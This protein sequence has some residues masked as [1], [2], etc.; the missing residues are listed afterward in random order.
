MLKRM[1]EPGLI[2]FSIGDL[3]FSHSMAHLLVR[4]MDWR[5]T[6]LAG[7]I[8]QPF[9]ASDSILAYTLLGSILWPI[10]GIIL[11]LAWGDVLSHVRKIRVGKPS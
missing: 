5:Y 6:D 8:S 2:A 11:W 1:L 10:L 4:V 9:D 3:F 7:I